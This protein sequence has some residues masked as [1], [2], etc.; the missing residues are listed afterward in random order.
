MAIIQFLAPIARKYINLKAKIRFPGK[1]RRKIIV[2]AGSL[3][4]F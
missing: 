2:F 3:K 1:V 4:L